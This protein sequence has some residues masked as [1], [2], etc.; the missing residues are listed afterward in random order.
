M[1][2]DKQSEIMYLR[3]R[4]VTEVE[5]SISSSYHS[6]L[7]KKLFNPALLLLTRTGLEYLTECA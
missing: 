1:I 3:E 7:K 6:R 5:Q 4:S 2:P